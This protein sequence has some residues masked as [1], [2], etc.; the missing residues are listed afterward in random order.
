MTRVYHALCIGAVKKNLRID[1]PIGRHPTDRKKMAVLTTPGARARSA[2]TYVEI[3]QRL[4]NYTLIKARLETGRTHQIRVH[5]AHV[6]HPV[7][8]DS[9]YGS[10]KNSFKSDGQILHAKFLKFVHPSFNEEMEF[11]SELPEY[12]MNA[13]ESVRQRNFCNPETRT[14]EIK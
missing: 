1:A 8:G 2:V 9:V 6:G 3:I 12:F 10:Q 5:M 7:L 14:I 4:G 11:D 13:I